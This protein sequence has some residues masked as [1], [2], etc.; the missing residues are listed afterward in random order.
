MSDI[1]RIITF[2]D[3]AEHT[4]FPSCLTAVR[5]AAAMVVSVLALAVIA[6]VI[7]AVLR[8]E[9]IRLYVNDG[10]IGADKLWSQTPVPAKTSS[11]AAGSRTRKAAKLPP[12]S[13]GTTDDPDQINLDP[14]DDLKAPTLGMGSYGG[15][16]QVTL[17][18]ANMTNLRVT[19]I[20]NNPGGR[21][22]ID[23]NDTT[24]TLIDDDM[25]FEIGNLVLGNFT[26]P[27]QTTITMQNRLK[28]DNSTTLTNIWK[29]YGGEISFSVMVRV[30]TNVTSYPL[31]KKTPTKSQTYVC[32][33]VTLG[34]TDYETYLVAN[35]DVE[36]RGA[37]S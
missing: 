23:C 36:C 33:H 32:R 24:V 16:D 35:D 30:S 11:V 25:Q 5:C 31:G 29:Y 34:L 15:N 18:R 28:I 26:V 37:S 13:A 4:R 12:E 6:L 17:Q 9:D 10:Y 2:V 1:K 20:A 7:H 21:T 22:K 14:F 19:L 27:P 3:D 8:S